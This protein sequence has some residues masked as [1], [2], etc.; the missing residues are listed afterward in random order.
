MVWLCLGGLIIIITVVGLVGR[1]QVGPWYR[2]GFFWY[3]QLG[4]QD[5]LVQVPCKTCDGYGIQYLSNGKVRNITP[6]TRDRQ[7]G[8]WAWFSIGAN[9]ISCPVCKGQGFT[10]EAKAPHN[11]HRFQR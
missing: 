9:K 11:S 2:D 4:S 10:L 1:L 5:Q 7:K 3:A 6:E 8:K